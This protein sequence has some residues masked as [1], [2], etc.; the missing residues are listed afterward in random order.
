MLD[1]LCKVVEGKGRKGCGIMN[2]YD[3]A[4]QQEAEI[5]ALK[6]ENEKLKNAEIF[7]KKGFELQNLSMQTLWDENKALKKENE[8][9]E[10]QIAIIGE[11]RGTVTKP[12]WGYL[13]VDDLIIYSKQQAEKEIP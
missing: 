3:M 5:A 11:F 13:D 7:T 9:L 6:K 1:V 8:R 4:I 10:R 2:I 12:Y